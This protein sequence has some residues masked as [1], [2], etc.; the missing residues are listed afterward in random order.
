MAIDLKVIVC[1]GD[2]RLDLPVSCE[3]PEQLISCVESVMRT[4]QSAPDSSSDAAEGVRTSNHVDIRTLTWAQQFVEIGKVRYDLDSAIAALRHTLRVI[5]PAPLPEVCIYYCRKQ[6]IKRTVSLEPQ[7]FE[8]QEMSV[9]EKPTAGSMYSF[10]TFGFS[11]PLFR[12]LWRFTT[13]L[14]FVMHQG[15]DWMWAETHQRLLL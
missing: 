11:S 6:L 3:T 1:E 7:S 8:M 5:K 10:F 12:P 14:S 2:E 9:K 13:T 4:F 15:A